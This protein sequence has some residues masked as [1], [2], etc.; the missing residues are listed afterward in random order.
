MAAEILPAGAD[1]KSITW[2]VLNGTGAASITQEGLLQAVSNGTVT[3]VAMAGD[4]SGIADSLQV[5][6]SNQFIPVSSIT[7]S[8]EGGLTTIDQDNGTLQ[9]LATIFPVNA[10]YKT[11]LW[12]VLNGTGRASIS[13][14]G[15]LQ[16]DSNGTVTVVA[17]TNDGSGVKNSMQIKISGQITGLYEINEPGIIIIADQV[18]KQLNIRWRVPTTDKSTIRIFNIMGSLVHIIQDVDTHHQIDISNLNAGYYILHI[19]KTKT[20]TTPYKF[21][22]E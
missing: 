15:L 10:S 4:G 19:S 3:V 2:S 13:D 7:L 17:R 8:G 20:A 11:I 16:A 1:D 18:N 6:I 12:S 22:V 14:T 21:L 9:M 5:T